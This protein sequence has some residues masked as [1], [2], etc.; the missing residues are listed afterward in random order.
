MGYPMCGMFPFRPVCVRFFCMLEEYLEASIK[1]H[2]L[3]RLRPKWCVLIFFLESFQLSEHMRFYLWEYMSFWPKF[4]F[5]HYL[6]HVLILV[7]PW[8]TRVGQR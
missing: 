4:P 5:L 6:D 2:T 8:G 7:S 1:S 3:H